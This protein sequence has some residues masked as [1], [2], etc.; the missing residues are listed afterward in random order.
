MRLSSRPPA[1]RNGRGN[2]REGKSADDIAKRGETAERPTTRTHATS[3]KYR[4]ARP[5]GMTVESPEFADCSTEF[6]C[7]VARSGRTWAARSVRRARR[8]AARDRPLAR[9]TTGG[10]R[11]RGVRSVARGQGSTVGSRDMRAYE[12]SRGGERLERE[13]VNAPIREDG[14]ARGGGSAY[15]SSHLMPACSV[16]IN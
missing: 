5:L 7:Y 3:G 15:T 12:R 4:R 14:T 1:L 13:M 8:F 2:G 11:A 10:T 9:A 6:S 16:V